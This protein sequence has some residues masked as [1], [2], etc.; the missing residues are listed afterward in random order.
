MY[1]LEVAHWMKRSASGN[2]CDVEGIA[3][4]QDHSHCVPRSEA[5]WGAAARPTFVVTD[6]MVGSNKVPAATVASIHRPHLPCANR[7]RFPLYSSSAACGGPTSLSMTRY[8]RR[9]AFHAWVSI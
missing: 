2:F 1:D 4:A 7:A 9:A 5:P 3:K 6:D 8:Q